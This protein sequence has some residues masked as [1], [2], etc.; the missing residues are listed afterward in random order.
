MITN[1]HSVTALFFNNKTLQDEIDK[2][3]YR[4]KL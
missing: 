4:Q 2:S 3:N 1:L